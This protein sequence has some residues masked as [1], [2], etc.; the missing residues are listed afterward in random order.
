[1][2]SKI[3]KHKIYR[4]IFVKGSGFSFAAVDDFKDNP[5]NKAI[6][7]LKRINGTSFN[8]ELSMVR[9][10][11]EKSLDQKQIRK[12]IDEILILY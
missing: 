1:M 3:K 7:Q 2:F 11:K 4:R 6:A 12:L 9:E 10:S 5:I 8:I